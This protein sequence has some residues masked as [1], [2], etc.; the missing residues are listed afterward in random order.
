MPPPSGRR[1]GTRYTVHGTRHTAHGTARHRTTR[2]GAR[3]DGAP[4]MR[5]LAHR[6]LRYAGGCRS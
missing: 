5:G 2:C 4:P 3:P 1:H 6:R